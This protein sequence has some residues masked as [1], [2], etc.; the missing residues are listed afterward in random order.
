MMMIRRRGSR[1]L[2]WWSFEINGIL[3]WAV[4]IFGTGAI[5]AYRV[6]K[7]RGLV[8]TQYVRLRDPIVLFS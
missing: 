1:S 2:T 4:R 8:F 3:N 7:D 6:D 5:G